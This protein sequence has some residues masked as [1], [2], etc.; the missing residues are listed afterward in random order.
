MA[1]TSIH[2]NR[3]T[4]CLC[5]SQLV[6][7]VADRGTTSGDITDLLYLRTWCD[8]PPP[9]HLTYPPP[10]AAANGR[11]RIATLTESFSHSGVNAGR[12]TQVPTLSIFNGRASS[13]S[14]GRRD[15]GG[16]FG[17]PSSFSVTA[18]VRSPPIALP[19]PCVPSSPRHLQL[20]HK[21]FHSEQHGHGWQRPEAAD[22]GSCPSRVLR[23]RAH[24]RKGQFCRREA[25]Q[26][27][28]NQ[29][30]GKCVW[31]FCGK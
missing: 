18:R 6:R 8:T 22:P 9:P 25:R 31:V 10:A 19:S 21:Q 15:G 11:L 5:A 27:P 24:F 4:W 23:H 12:A 13:G 16:R 29:E 1:L 7:C 17:S 3:R 20:V 30:R 28:H 2:V 14:G 26:T